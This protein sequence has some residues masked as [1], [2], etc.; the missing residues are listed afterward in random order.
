MVN[1]IELSQV[2]DSCQL[3][4]PETVSDDHGQN[5]KMM[6]LWNGER[7]VFGLSRSNWTMVLSGSEWYT[8]ACA[9]ITCV[10]DLGLSDLPVTVTGLNNINWN[11]NWRILSFGW[12]IVGLKPEHIKWILEL[13]R[14]E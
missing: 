2:T 9:K 13:E 14:Y 8:G 10:R 1:Y 6:N 5:V 7:I 11:G 12:K 4:A 3:T